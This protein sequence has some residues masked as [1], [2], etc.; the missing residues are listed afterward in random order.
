MNTSKIENWLDSKLKAFHKEALFPILCIWLSS[1][2]VGLVVR[3]AGP[4]VPLQ[5]LPVINRVIVVGAL[6]IMII[7]GPIGYVLAILGLKRDWVE[8]PQWFKDN[9]KI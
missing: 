2:I 4:S 9:F 5:E 3:F 6:W 1:I 8:K 7:L